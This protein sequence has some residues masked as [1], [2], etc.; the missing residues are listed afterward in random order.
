M[1]GTLP[2]DTGGGGGE[3]QGCTVSG[4]DL[5]DSQFPHDACSS[6][7]GGWFLRSLL[8]SRGDEKSSVLLGRPAFLRAILV[9]RPENMVAS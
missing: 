4:R 7:S 9:A 3:N 5:Y 6:S 8:G 1:R 2:R